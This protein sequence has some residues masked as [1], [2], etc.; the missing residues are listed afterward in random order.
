MVGQLYDKIAQDG[1]HDN[2]MVLSDLASK[3]RTF[4]RWAMAH[5]SGSA[6]MVGQWAGIS[7]AINETELLAELSKNKDGVYSYL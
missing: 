1:R 2:I 4:S 7:G 5:L 6:E 3:E